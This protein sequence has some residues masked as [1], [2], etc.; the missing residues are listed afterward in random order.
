MNRGSIPD[1]FGPEYRAAVFAVRPRST[2]GYALAWVLLDE[3][4]RARSTTVVL[5]Q[6]LLRDLT[7]LHGRSLD[8]ARDWL[9]E[10]DLL[11]VTSVVAG[12]S[13]RTEYS[14]RMTAPAPVIPAL[15]E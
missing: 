2:S 13:G 5:G 4:F 12:Q 11:D 6:R 15:D 9:V 7:Q 10:H 14:L 1:R 8:R 3:A